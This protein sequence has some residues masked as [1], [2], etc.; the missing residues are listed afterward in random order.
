MFIK[1]LPDQM[2]QFKRTRARNREYIAITQ[3]EE[4]YWKSIFKHPFNNH[5]MLN[6]GRRDQERLR[7]VDWVT[8]RMQ[9]VMYKCSERQF[10]P[11]IDEMVRVTIVTKTLS[12]KNLFFFTHQI[13]GCLYLHLERITDARRIFDLMKDVAEE[14]RNWSQAMQSY[15]WIGRLL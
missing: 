9:G 4:K 5:R 12:D 15:N 11:M 13:L 1:R 3:N 6:D 8:K 2:A 10:K 7:V 14:T